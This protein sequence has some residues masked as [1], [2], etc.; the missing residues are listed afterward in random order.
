MYLGKDKK[1]V[2]TGTTLVVPFCTDCGSQEIKAVYTCKNCKSHNIK[3]PNIIDNDDERG[4]KKE[5]KEID[6]YKY[7][8]DICG[9]EYE[10]TTKNET[11][12][13]IYCDNNTFGVGEIYSDYN[14]NFNYKFKEDICPNCLDK[15]TNILNK[16]L[17]SIF[18]SKHI[19]AI[20]NEFKLSD[21]NNDIDTINLNVYDF[22]EVTMAAPTQFM[23]FDGSRN[24]YFF[25]YRFGK[26]QLY[27]TTLDKNRVILKEGLYGESLDGYISKENFLK[28]M[29]DNGIKINI[30]SHTN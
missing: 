5:T 10:W 30:K 3:F 26:W 28:L 9:K 16:E 2:E 22:E 7:K 21:A 25:R 11:P 20:K 23:F 18:D 17:D 12:N 24:E 14:D 8:C 29:L 27:K 13:N 4:L 1:L 15:I 6:V 19:E